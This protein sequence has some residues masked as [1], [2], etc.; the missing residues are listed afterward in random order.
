MTK[1]S[2]ISMAIRICIYLPLIIAAI[3]EIFYQQEQQEKMCS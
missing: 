3:G 2:V 1:E